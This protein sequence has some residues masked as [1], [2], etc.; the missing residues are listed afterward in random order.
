MAEDTA[1]TESFLTGYVLFRQGE[2]AETCFILKSGAVDLTRMDKSGREIRF[3]TLGK[4][5]ILGEMSM[6]L[7]TQRTATATARETTEVAEI[8]KEDF[9][10]Q[11][12]RLNPFMQRLIRLIVQRLRDTTSTLTRA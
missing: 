8:S 4:G 2:D 11:M 7:G 6:I 5:E 10:S 9:D 1:K 3:A 12:E